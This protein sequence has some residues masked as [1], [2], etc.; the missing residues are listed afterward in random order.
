M[1][2]EGYC[3]NKQEQ[4][5]THPVEEEHYFTHSMLTN[6]TIVRRGLKGK[7][8]DKQYQGKTEPTVIGLF[9]V[10]SPRENLSIA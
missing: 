5:S 3:S 1:G 7:D 8:P 10:D 4:L 6:M 9:C 2:K